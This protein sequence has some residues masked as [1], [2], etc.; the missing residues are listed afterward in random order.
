MTV[1]SLPEGSDLPRVIGIGS[2]AGGLEALRAIVPHLPDRADVEFVLL[3]HTS[4]SH[5]S[6]L[7][8]ILQPLSPLPVEEV[9][10]GDRPRGRRLLVTPAN[11]HLRFDGRCYR[12]DPTDAHP[13][14]R[15]NISLFLGSLAEHLGPRAGGVVLTGTGSDGADGLRRIQAAGGLVLCQSVGSARYT[16]M[17]EA[18]LA[19]IGA[20]NEVDLDALTA[21]LAAELEAQDHPAQ[22]DDTDPGADDASGEDPDP[23]PSAE[24]TRLFELLRARQGIELDHYKPG[25]VQRRLIKRM[26]QAGAGD[27]AAYVAHCEAH[28]EELDALALDLLIGVTSFWRDPKA[29]AAL[30]HELQAWPAGENPLRAWVA[31]CSTGEEAYSIAIALTEALEQAPRPRSV[32]V[33]ATD[34]S[35]TALARARRGVYPAQALHRLGEDR[36]ARHFIPTKGGMEVRAALRERVVFSRHDLIKDAPFP[37]MDL[38]TCRNV[39]IYLQPPAQERALS[40]F[41][42]ALRPGGLL[43]LGRSETVLSA[44]SY[45]DVIDKS[46][47]LFRRNV[48][49]RPSVAPSPLSRSEVRAVKDAQGQFPVRAR[50]ATR[51]PADTA[52]RL[53]KQYVEQEIHGAMLL[54][55]QGRLLHV[56]GEVGPLFGLN[57]GQQRLDLPALVRPEFASQLRDL[58]T[59]DLLPGERRHAVIQ[60]TAGRRK[61]RWVLSLGR[62][63]DDATQLLVIRPQDRSAGIRAADWRPATGTEPLSEEAKGRLR[64]LVEQLESS[65]E[66]MQALN[67][68]AQATNEELQSANEELEASNEELQ[69]TNQELVTVNAELGHQWQAYR[70]LSE[71][72]VSVLQSIDMPVIVLGEDLCLQRFN[73]A[74][75]AL[76][77][78]DPG[79]VGRHVDTMKRPAGMPDLRPRLAAFSAS[80]SPVYEMLPVLTDGRQYSLHLSH[81]IQDRRRDGMV[82]TF[83]DHTK[84]AAAE[85]AVTNLERRVLGLLE[86]GRGLISIKD[87]QG[88]YQYANERYASFLGLTRD[89]LIG[90]TDRQALPE[91]VALPLRDRDLEA[92]QSPSGTEHEELLRVGEVQRVWWA[93]RFVLQD[94]DGSPAAVCIQAIDTTLAHEEDEHRRISSRVLD[95]TSEGVVITN[96]AGEIL[97]VNRAFTKITGY[98]EHEVLGRLPSMLKSNRHDKDFF[99]RMWAAIRRDGGWSGEIWNCRKDGTEFP[100]LLSISAL[101]DD[102]GRVTHYVGVFADISQLVDSREHLMRMATQDVLTGLP[103]RRKLSERLEIALARAARQDTEVALC[104]LDVDNFKTVNDSLGHEAGDDLLKEIA[105]HLTDSLRLSDTVA[106]LGG[107][108]FVV[109]L[110]PTTR[111]ETLLTVERLNAALSGTLR[112]RGQDMPCGVSIGIAMY[113]EDGADGATLMQHADAAMYRAKQAGKGRYEFFSLEAANEARHRLRLEVGLREALTHDQFRLHYQPQFALD[114]GRLVGVEALLRWQMDDGRLLSPASFL[115]VTEESNLIEGIGRWALNEALRQLSAWRDQ[116]APEITMS[117][118]VSARQLRHRGFVDEVQQALYAH[119]IPGRQLVLELTETSLLATG[120]DIDMLMSR[121]KALD[122]QISLDDFG[123]GYS[124]LAM[125]RRLEIQE[126]KIDREFVAGLADDR[127]DREIVGAIVGMARG[128][129]LR[130]VAEGLET[131]AQRDQLRS[132][133]ATVIGQGYLLGRPQASSVR[134]WVTADAGMERTA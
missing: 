35:E 62:A 66:E 73:P 94:A 93:N 32:Q 46:Q 106:R 67:E 92:L 15:P 14:P 5:R 4:P 79:S 10:D 6:L 85:R 58:T 57:P 104:F 16:G 17:P 54:D 22:P 27:V 122:V 84:A 60:K 76:F 83:A 69:A 71:E 63:V 41:A 68:E 95:V 75:Q 49:A 114:S 130:V 2:S 77:Q 115:R 12:L 13:L 98:A 109:M 39:L 99:D 64:E 1:R 24:R 128:L 3:Q 80:A 78:L 38:V 28:P 47:R 129:G 29:Y 40:L 33:F 56:Q 124:S 48:I 113:P 100:E 89:A 25:T 134:P 133:D 119:S 45:F 88:R 74:A 43:L 127:S 30:L 65:N 70:Q 103:N 118:N 18:S 110:E 51:D 7:V 132:L 61:L 120:A 34:L 87:T 11:A 90:R 112:V 8:E 111:H 72:L 117:V 102:A 125:L 123:T 108:E 81:R 105:R 126:L 52:E 131:L 23:P 107:D 20:A 26:H 21:R 9:V 53:L 91:A 121:L 97:R 116:G 86:H 19:L 59:P 96:E 82:L 101:C 44:T 55:T 50:P 37:R 36:I 42:Y 31:G